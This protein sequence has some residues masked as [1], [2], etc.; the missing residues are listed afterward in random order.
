MLVF[1][2]FPSDFV[3]IYIFRIRF[4]SRELSGLKL[5]ASTF[6]HSYANKK[7]NQPAWPSLKQISIYTEKAEGG[8]EIGIT[9]TPK[10]GGSFDPP[11]PP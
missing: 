2:Y 5:T 9:L 4:F 3:M 8:F 11:P 1:Y 10:L 6:Y 7:T